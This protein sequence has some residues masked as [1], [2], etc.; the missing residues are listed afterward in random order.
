MSCRK[1]VGSE[2]KKR[3]LDWKLYNVLQ[4]ALN[5]AGS[6][7]AKAGVADQEDLSMKFTI[8]TEHKERRK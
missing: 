3:W 6:A 7:S 5:V 4:W 2:Q 8:R 1:T